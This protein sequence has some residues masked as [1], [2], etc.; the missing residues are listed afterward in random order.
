MYEVTKTD[1]IGFDI[2]S[3]DLLQH[4]LRGS[5]SFTLPSGWDLSTYA[6]STIDDQ[7]LT[8]SLGLYL[9]WSF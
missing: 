8:F 1:Q 4:R 2:G 5:R 6:E 7:L 9:Q 3:D